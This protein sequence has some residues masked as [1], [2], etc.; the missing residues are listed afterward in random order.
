MGKQAWYPGR[1]PSPQLNQIQGLL[2]KSSLLWHLVDGCSLYQV[3]FQVYSEEEARAL[4][5]NPSALVPVAPQA[6]L[7][8]S[9]MAKSCTCSFRV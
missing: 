7:L 5:G 8:L 6:M 9:C 2:Q 4:M 1:R 3:F